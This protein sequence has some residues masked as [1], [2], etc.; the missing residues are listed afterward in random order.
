MAVDTAPVILVVDD[1]ESARRLVRMGLELEGAVV[2]EADTLARARQYLNRRMDGVVLDRELPDGDGLELLADI[3]TTCP[4]V[5]IVVNSTVDDRRE[6]VWV[7]KVDK[8]DLPEIVRGLD[9]TATSVA[10][11]ELAVV[12]LVRAE[13]EALVGDW[14]ELCRWDPLLPPDSEPPV[15]RLVVDAIIDALQRPQPIGWGPD[16]ALASVTELFASSAGAIDVAIGQL[17][18]LR[19]AFRRHIAGQVPAGEEQETRARVDMLI[20]RAI[21]TTSRV[22]AARLQRQ[23][24]FDPLTGV[25]NRRSFD[26]E[27]ESELNRA[28]RYERDLTVVIAGFDGVDQGDLDEAA[29][30]QVRRLAGVFATNLRAQDG[31]FRI[32]GATFALLLPET[33]P[34]GG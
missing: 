19:E 34:A 32:D 12:D 9:L 30:A 5:P 10:G 11:A 15:P 2:V 16:P 1:D 25:G 20:D 7:V 3:G 8:G 24:T 27:L 13:A 14:R 17:V 18:C 23:A 28:Y 29:E 33:S 31:V 6:P 26:A 4:D 22:A 21:W